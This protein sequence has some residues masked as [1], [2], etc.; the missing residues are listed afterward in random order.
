MTQTDQLHTRL[1]HVFGAFGT[2]M[3]EAL[4][5]LIMISSA[6]GLSVMAGA[7]YPADAPWNIMIA[8]PK[9]QLSIGALSTM[10]SIIAYALTNDKAALRRHLISAATFTLIPWGQLNIALV[11]VFLIGS[12][13]ELQSRR[14]LL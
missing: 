4:L 14:H 9:L 12:A 13:N 10:L 5:M 11:A 1:F 3:R 7:S 2:G 6:I 8:E